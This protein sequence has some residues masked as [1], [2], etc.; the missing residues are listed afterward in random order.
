MQVEARRGAA[1]I[2]VALFTAVIYAT[3][4][5]APVVWRMFARRAGGGSEV[6]VLAGL[7]LTAFAVLSYAVRRAGPIGLGRTAAV[8]A[9]GAA[10]VAIIATVELT[11]AEKLHF[12]YYGALAVLVYQALKVD[13]AGTALVVVTILLVA[14]IGFGD[15]VIQGIIPRRVF[16]WKDVALNAVSGLLATALILVFEAEEIE[17]S[18]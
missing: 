12:L 15:E 16:E 11:P 1:W 18:R 7:V 6:I 4:P 3:L 13:L 8:V 5:V 9:V 10:Y 2:R 17:S 14:L